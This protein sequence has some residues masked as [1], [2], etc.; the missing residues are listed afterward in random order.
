MIC[1]ISVKAETRTNR[2]GSDPRSRLLKSET[3]ILFIKGQYD[4]AP[5]DCKRR[6]KINSIGI[7]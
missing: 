7:V 3:G 2:P 1:I 5:A 6:R 4:R